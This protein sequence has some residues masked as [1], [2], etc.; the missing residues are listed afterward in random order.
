M[1]CL[2]AASPSVCFESQDGRLKSVHAFLT[3]IYSR[4]AHPGLQIL[5]PDKPREVTG[6]PWCC[7]LAR[8]PPQEHLH[9]ISSRSVG[10]RCP[11]PTVSPQDLFSWSPFLCFTSD[12]SQSGQLRGTWP[13]SVHVHAEGA[14]GPSDLQ[15]LPPRV[16]EPEVLTLENDTQ[17]GSGRGSSLF[18]GPT[19]LCL[20]GSAA[21]PQMLKM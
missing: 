6:P 14:D 5:L 17:D 19:R 9:V 7:L 2:R 16:P 3:I 13:R 10:H 1:V 12:C 8:C 18:S 11:P 4:G 21:L 20:H 15:L